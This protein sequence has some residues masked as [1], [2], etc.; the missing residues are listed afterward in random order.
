MPYRLEGRL[1]QNLLWRLLAGTL[2]NESQ[3]LPSLAKGRRL[4][5]SL[6]NIRPA[7]S[8]PTPQPGT[9]VASM[10]VSPHSLCQRRGHLDTTMGGSMAFTTI[11]YLFNSDL[12]ADPGSRSLH[13]R[14]AFRRRITPFIGA[15]ILPFGGGIPLLLTPVCLPR[16][17]HQAAFKVSPGR[18]TTT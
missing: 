7:S 10:L 1:Q 8:R 16:G 4:P 5:R 17:A 12:R 6:I 9:S 2:L 3:R 15:R 18:R 14:A 13:G 11:Q